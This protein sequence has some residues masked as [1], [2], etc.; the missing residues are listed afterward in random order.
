MN[1]GVGEQYNRCGFVEVSIRVLL[2]ESRGKMKLERTAGSNIKS[3][4]FHF[5]NEF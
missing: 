2:K 5:K 1:H 3:L 4:N